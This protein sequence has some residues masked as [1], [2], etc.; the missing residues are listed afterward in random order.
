MAAGNKVLFIVNPQS[1]GGRT[2]KQWKKVER[3]LR[4]KNY[5]FDVQPT[6]RAMHACE[7]AGDALRKGYDHIIAVG[8]DGTINEVVNGF[9]LNHEDIRERAFL[10]VLPMGTGSDFARVLPVSASADYVEK[11][12]TDCQEMACDI[13]KTEYLGWNG[14]PQTRYF[15]NVADVGVGCETCI[16]L[17]KKSKVMGGFLSF[18]LTF[19]GVLFSFKSPEFTVEVD[20]ELFYSGKSSLLAI[21][22]GKY[23]GGGVM[24]APQAS[25]DDGLMDIMLLKDANTF[26][27]LTALPSAYKGKHLDHPKI[28]LT[29]GR[30]VKLSS[31]VHIGLEMDGE[32]PGTGDAMIRI[33]PAGIKLFV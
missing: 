33:V 16:R 31:A 30:Q 13:I 23:F 17:N 6:E 25:L 4:M 27:F 14:S 7:I 18:L 3:W 9:F 1:G 19:L 29:Q 5:S 8:G 26:D 28:K 32:T 22:N 21:N 24:I 20:G 11:L 2:S 12:L 10:S 15:I